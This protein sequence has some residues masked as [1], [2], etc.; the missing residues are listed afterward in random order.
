MSQGITPSQTVGPFLAIGLP[1]DDGPFV[2][3]PGPPGS[4][5]IEGQVLDGA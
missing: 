2:V 4:I 5:V 3:P 1:W